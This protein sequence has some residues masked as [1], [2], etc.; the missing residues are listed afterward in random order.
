MKKIIA[1]VLALWV[2]APVTALIK[3]VMA[4]ELRSD[5]TVY[6]IPVKGMIE[7]A[8]LYVIQRGLAEAEEARAGAIIFVMDTPG[9]TLGAASQI[10]RTLQKVTVPTYT[11]V[12]K[13]AFSAGAI[14]ALA[15]D[16]IYMAPGSVI[17]D[18]MPIMMSPMGGAPQELSPD[19]Q[20]KMVSGVAA[21]IRS[22]A[23]ESGHDP[24]LAEKMVRRE[25]EY[26]IGDEVIS[27][28]NQLLTLTNVEAERKVD[29][30]GKP[31]LS[32]GT[33]QDVDEL[34]ARIG[35]PNATKKTLEVTS[36]EK[37]ARYIAA[38]AP[39]LFAAGLLGIYI[40]IKTPG[41]GL[42]GVLGGICLALFF[43]GH[44]IA[45][46]SGMEEVL[47]F[48]LGFALV[49]LEVLLF[50][51]A[52]FLAVIGA[53]LMLWAILTAM[54]QQFPGGPL[55]PEFP[56]LQQPLQNFAWGVLL[57][58]VLAMI[59]ARFLPK[60]SAFARIAL[61]TTTSSRAG[62]TAGP[63][64]STATL[65]GVVGQTTTALRPGGSAMLQ[66]QPYDVISR[67]EFIDAGVR[68]KVVEAQG[69]RIIVERLS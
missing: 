54:V 22:A 23:Q 31:L 62:Y 42:P 41:F 19:V 58:A 50:P 49:A 2:L 59:A 3:P 45:G 14:I 4:Q 1:I 25:I 9:G 35:R 6:I 63:A 24:Q 34:L 33:V 15:T 10:V 67:G 37:I 61:A 55:I 43:W 8:L 38:M 16:H 47:I 20:E 17:G 60:T 36:A 46:L 66:D 7:P 44:H 40:E 69:S 52:G 11:F 57:A 27:P 56:D 68:I 65:V 53:V 18:A 30:A 21:L 13:D 28:S 12:E 26:K 32:A 29:E 51:T 39:I 48:L 64:I 5:D